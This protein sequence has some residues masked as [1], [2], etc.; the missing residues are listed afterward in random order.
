LDDSLLAAVAVGF[1]AQMIDGALGMAYGI[2][3]TA[4]LL[5]LNVPPAPASAAVHTAEMIV[6]GVSGLAHLRFGNVDRTLFRRL[7]LPGVIGGALGAALLSALPGERIK[8]F[9]SAYLLAMGV[10]ICYRA[11]TKS[12]PR[13]PQRGVAALGLAG[14]FFDAIGGGGWGPIV[15]THLVANGHEPR[16]AVGSVNLAEFFVTVAEATTFFLTLGI[17]HWRIIVGLVLGGVV[18]APLAAHSA[19][20]L[21]ARL[22]KWMVGLLITGLSLNTLLRAL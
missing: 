9:V 2:S 7:V 6:T 4:F 17:V 13:P 5:S 19:R 12:S 14:G 16:L 22:I 3:S 8:P 11:A 18:A 10:Y 15:T 20:R 1:V 21:P